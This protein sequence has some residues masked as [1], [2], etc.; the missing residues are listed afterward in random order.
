MKK[1]VK[2]TTLAV[3]TIALLSGCVQQQPQLEGQN[4]AIYSNSVVANVPIENKYRD[5][6]TGHTVIEKHYIYTPD[7]DLKEAVVILAKKIEILERRT[8]G[9][10][11]KKAKYIQPARKTQSNTS[12]HTKCGAYTANK[13]AIVYRSKSIK[14]SK[15]NRVEKGD[16]VNFS[17]C[18]THG[19]CELEGN[20]GYVQAWKFTKA[21]I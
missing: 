8:S 17:G 3:A 18:D 20:D 4:G 2:V 14:A 16:V 9:L 11:G 5:P 6:K 21:V 7:V 19:W 15:S 10:V 13:D 12:K 1:Y